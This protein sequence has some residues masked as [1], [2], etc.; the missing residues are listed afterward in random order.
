MAPV[1]VKPLPV[2]VYVTAFSVTPGAA[3]KVRPIVP[4][5]ST[6]LRL[7]GSLEHPPSGPLAASASH[8]RGTLPSLATTPDL[9]W[10]FL[11]ERVLSLERVRRAR[12]AGERRTLTTGFDGHGRPRLYSR[13]RSTMQEQAPAPTPGFRGRP[14]GPSGAHQLAPADRLVY[15]LRPYP[16]LGIRL[17]DELKREVSKR[18]TF[19]II[20]HP[21]AG[22]TTMTE[23][24]L[25][26]GG[27]IHLAGVG[28]EVPGSSSDRQRLDGDRA[29]SAGSRS[30]PACSSSSTRAVA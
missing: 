20:S 3:A 1:L 4:A 21:D 5:V 13:H 19:A 7:L 29:R 2:M 26:Y 22:K 12:H 10:P 9:P 8:M 16:H 23:K 28:Q 27:A 18:R 14:G 11:I 17:D 15:D 30:P 25:L 6:S 24:L